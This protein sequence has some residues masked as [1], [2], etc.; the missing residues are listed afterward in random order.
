MK[1][2]LVNYNFT[3]D[4]YWIGEDYLIYD[5]SDSKDFLKDFDQSKIIYTEN[6]GQVDFDKLSYLIENY[7][8]LP[9]VFLWG[10]TNLFKYITPEEYAVLK[11]NQH[12][13]PLLTQTHQ[14]YSD[15]KGL[16]CYYK[17]GMYCE[18]NPLLYFNGSKIKD[19]PAFAEMFGF[20]NPDYLPF[21][22]GGNYIL[23]KE[24]VH[25]HPK[26]LYVKLKELLPYTRDPLEAHLCERAYY[27]LWSTI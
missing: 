1:K 25:K 19:Y 22:P 15:D 12:F 16:V 4:K 17:N 26:E 5:R 9:D 10:K 11:D 27:T 14:T 20:P 2:I 21:A 23:T 24:A 6:V 18:R 8:H 3:P 7:D 13:T